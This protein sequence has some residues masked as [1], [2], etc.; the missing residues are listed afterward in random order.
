MASSP[1]CKDKPLPVRGVLSHSAY[2]TSQSPQVTWAAH[3]TE[4]E[5]WVPEVTGH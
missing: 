5:S 1:H 3:F 4:V 2:I